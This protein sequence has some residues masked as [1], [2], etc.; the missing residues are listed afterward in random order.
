LWPG[1]PG[2]PEYRLLL[3][4]LLCGMTWE[5]ALDTDAAPEPH[6]LRAGAELL[7]AVVRHWKALGRTSI[8]G[9]REGFV[10]RDGRLTPRRD[11]WA[12]TVERRAQDILLGKLPWGI[13]VVRL[14]WLRPVLVHVDW[15]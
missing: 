4:K 12:L 6:H 3:P 14:P 1:D 13:S 2:I 10:L 8:D 11:G 5:E 15:A 7:E 9:L